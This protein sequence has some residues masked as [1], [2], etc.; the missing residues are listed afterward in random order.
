M[1]VS[2]SSCAYRVSSSSRAHRPGGGPPRTR[3]RFAPYL[4]GC[5]VEICIGLFF[6]FVESL[7]SRF[8]AAFQAPRLK[9]MHDF[10]LK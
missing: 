6:A 3:D 7:S 1:T 5:A 4:P 8:R 10:P 9:E 2:G